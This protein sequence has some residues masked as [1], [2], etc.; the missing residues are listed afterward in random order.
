M[1]QIKICYSEDEA[2]RFLKNPHISVISICL[3]FSV[4]EETKEQAILIY[5][6]CN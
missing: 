6:G 3:G 4:V 1:K 5:Y 2:N